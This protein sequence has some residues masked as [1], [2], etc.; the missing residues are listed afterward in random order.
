MLK[1]IGWLVKTSMLAVLVFAAGI[2]GMHYAQTHPKS[3]KT[4]T[5]M[6]KTVSDQIKTHLAHAES[7][8]SEV[9]GEIKDWA[10]HM[11]NEHRD[12]VVKKAKKESSAAAPVLVNE[13]ASA[14]PR[15]AP[16]GAPK[17]ENEEISSTEQ[18][19]LRALMREL[20][21]GSHSAD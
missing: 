7:A 19:K 15:V 16:Q 12:G 4:Q 6:T 18:Q 2:Y 20:N 1:L 21:T 9:V 17:S 3:L 11:T 8:E 10:Q 5:Q 14:Q 13:H